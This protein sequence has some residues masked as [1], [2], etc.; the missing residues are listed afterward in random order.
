MEPS[1]AIVSRAAGIASLAAPVAGVVRAVLVTEGQAVQVGDLIARLDDRIAQAAVVRA[2]SSVHFAEQTLARDKEL[3]AQQNTSLRRFE[4]SS[5]ALAVAKADLDSA[6]GVLD[7]TQVR[8]PID[9]IVSRVLVTRGQSVDP[10]GVVAEVLN[11]NRLIVAA[12]VPADD[13]KRVN[14]GQAAH[15]STTRSGDVG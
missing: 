7:Q 4:E 2:R 13:V 5:Q 3:L 6:R 14:I 8:S 10:N 11:R 15:V 12:R 9:G 1:P